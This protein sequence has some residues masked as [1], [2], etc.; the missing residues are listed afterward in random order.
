MP[1]VGIQRE[2]FP[3]AGMLGMWLLLRP[4]V[5]QEGHRK[6]QRWHCQSEE[7]GGWFRCPCV[8]SQTCQALRQCMV[9]TYGHL[10]DEEPC[11][12]SSF[13]NLLLGLN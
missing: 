1:L 13:V 7:L 11:P 9:S 4:P 6:E 5:S 8:R 2:P 12:D 3:G 10:E